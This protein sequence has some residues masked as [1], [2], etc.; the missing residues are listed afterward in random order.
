MRVDLNVPKGWNFCSLAQLRAISAIIV[1]CEQESDGWRQ[2]GNEDVKVA[3]FFRLTGLEIVSDVDPSLPVDEQYYV[4]RMRPYSLEDEGRWHGLYPWWKRLTA[5]LSRHGS[6]TFPLYV[7]QLQ[8]WLTKRRR[9]KQEIPG[10]LDWLDTKK[11]GH[12]LLFPFS[13]VNRRKGRVGESVVFHGPA[14]FMDGFTWQRYRFCQDYMQAVQTQENALLKMTTEASK[15]I[16]RRGRVSKQQRKRMRTTVRQLLAMARQVDAARAQF[17][18]VVFTRR[19][20]YIDRQTGKQQ[21]DFH[22]K[23]GQEADNVDYFMDFP[24][25]D[26]QLV[27]LWWSGIMHWLSKQYPKVFR[28]QKVGGRGRRP[29]NPLE[30]YTRTTATLEKYLHATAE[31]IDN[32]PYTTILQ[33]LQDIT[34]KNEEMEKINRRMKSKH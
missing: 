8:Y 26:W 9:G 4:C 27:L 11:G 20:T 25:A 28:E 12:L 5:R 30:V 10:V 32:E 16:P 15:M 6:D 17:L 13:E 22:Y 14:P 21:Y 18:A 23:A 2:Y 29:V 34:V 33:Q 1:A 3:V 19:I 24:K 7:W 31:E